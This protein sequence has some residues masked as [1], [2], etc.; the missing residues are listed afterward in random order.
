MNNTPIIQEQDSYGN[1]KDEDRGC[2]RAIKEAGDLCKNKG[3]F[4]SLWIRNK[5]S[6][7]KSFHSNF[8]QIHPPLYTVAEI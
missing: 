2:R 5:V 6:K 7:Q 4:G 3:E 1:K 8:R